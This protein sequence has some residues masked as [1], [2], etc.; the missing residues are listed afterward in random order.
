M[1]TAK[2][3]FVVESEADLL[4][5]EHVRARRLERGA[6]QAQL[7]SAGNQLLRQLAPVLPRLHNKSSDL[8]HNM[9]CQYS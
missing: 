5:G 9:S 8:G 4:L 2:Q 7:S 1:H 3:C 6:D